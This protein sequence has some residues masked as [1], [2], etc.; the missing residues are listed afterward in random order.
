MHREGSAVVLAPTDVAGHL[1][2]R[3]LTQLRR[4]IAEGR[5]RVALPPDPR[6]EALRYRGEQHEAAYVESLRAQ[7]LTTVD[8]RGATA[9]AATLE[10]MRDG[11][12]IIVQAPLAAGGLA[13]RA[14]ILR[15]VPAPSALGVFSYEPADTKLS[16]ETRA[17]T[18]LQLCA[19][20]ALLTEVQAREPARLHV[21]T[22]IATESYRTAEC[23]AY[24]RHVRRTLEGVV[25]L[26]PP[27]PTYA[28]PVP[29]C[30]VCTLWAHCDRRRRGDDHLSLTADMRTLHARELQRQG[31]ATVAGLAA[32][33]GALPGQPRRGGLPTFARLAHQARLQ[34]RARA[35]GRPPFDVLD[36]ECGRGL[37][38]LP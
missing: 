5:M 22:P 28:D 31:I 29:H 9:A 35:Q 38:R 30:D 24:F 3:H 37:C 15:R 17:G 6:M 26:E 10:A 2:C 8:L 12:E 25:A 23:A 19:Y 14:D 1:A 32:T 21:V 11:V 16:R 36:V 33:G 4:A 7:G 27:P 34:V 13:G 18:L 20:A